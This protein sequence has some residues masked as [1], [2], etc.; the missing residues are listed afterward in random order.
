MILSILC[1]LLVPVLGATA[2]S[3]QQEP[4]VFLP[5]STAP[6]GIHS[7]RSGQQCVPKAGIIQLDAEGVRKGAG[8]PKKDQQGGDC[9]SWYTGALANVS[10][11][12]KL[13]EHYS[14]THDPGG[15]IVLFI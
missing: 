15:I 5:E 4:G 6:C 12:S 3:P 13:F 14:A 8:W 11:L 10:A 2:D 1:V 7:D 9:D